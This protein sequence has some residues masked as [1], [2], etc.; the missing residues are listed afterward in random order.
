MDKK[1]ELDLTGDE[2]VINE[3]H[4]CEYCGAERSWCNCEEEE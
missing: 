2:P 4:D 1:Y 3:V